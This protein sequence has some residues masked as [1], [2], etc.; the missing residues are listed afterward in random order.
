MK[1]TSYSQAGQDLFVHALIPRAG[2]Y[3]E[4]GCCHPIEV[5]NTY[6]LEQIGW[7]G[8]GVD[9]DASAVA[10]HEK[11]RKNIAWVADATRIEWDARLSQ[12]APPIGP[13]FDY[14]SL[15]ID[16]ASLDALH[17]FFRHDLSARIITAE[18][19]A[20]R[21]GDRLRKP[22][23]DTLV[24]LG[25]RLICADVCS[26]DGAPYEDWWTVSELFDDAK[27]FHGSGMKWCDILRQGGIEV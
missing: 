14:L 5:S 9:I 13:C 11:M 22:M 19:D 25:F 26:A 21:N 27:R 12:V 17:N 20:Y 15:D 1:F 16:E 23:R 10:L 7:R 4:I 18:H 6:G 24:Y 3:I 2:T 8:V